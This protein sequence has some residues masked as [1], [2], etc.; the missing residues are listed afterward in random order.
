MG[1]KTRIVD[2]APNY[3]SSESESNELLKLCG[4]LLEGF[5]DLLLPVVV[6]WKSGE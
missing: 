1:I 2:P 4:G 6:E 3:S 5:L